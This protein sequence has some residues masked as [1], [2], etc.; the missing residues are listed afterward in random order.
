MNIVPGVV[1][2]AFPDVKPQK[3]MLALMNEPPIG[4]QAN[5]FIEDFYLRAEFHASRGP[6]CVAKAF[7]AARDIPKKS[8]LFVHYGDNYEEIRKEL[9]YRVG[10][11]TLG[12]GEKIPQL[13][14]P[15]EV[16]QYLPLDCFVALERRPFVPFHTKTTPK[17][18]SSQQQKARPTENQSHSKRHSKRPP[19]NSKRPRGRP[20][21]GKTWDGKLARYV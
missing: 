14:D 6:V 1:F 2:N 3:D 5:V 12:K 7:Y 19:H 4:K 8:E 18:N 11:P 15:L 21:K 17:A 13:Q 16:M 20:P 9:N 10:M